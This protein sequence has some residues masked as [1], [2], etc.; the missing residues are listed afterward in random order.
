MS[1]TKLFMR[2]KHINVFGRISFFFP[3]YKFNMFSTITCQIQNKL[4][5]FNYKIKKPWH[6]GK[7]T[8]LNEFKSHY[9]YTE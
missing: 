6:Y 3:K 9:L 4:K 2:E 5:F 1:Q 8:S 7:I